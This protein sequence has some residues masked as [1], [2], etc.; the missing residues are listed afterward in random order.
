MDDGGYSANNLLGNAFGRHDKTIRHIKRKFI[1]NDVTKKS[2]SSLLPLLVEPCFLT[3]PRPNF[4]SVM[5][6]SRIHQNV[7]T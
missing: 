4:D 1:L 3:H 6:I 2:M 7:C 5:C